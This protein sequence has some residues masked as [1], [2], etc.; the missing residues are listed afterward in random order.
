MRVE[1]TVSRQHGSVSTPIVPCTVAAVLIFG[2]G[3]LVLGSTALA[4]S[5]TVLTFGIVLVVSAL[6][7]MV[8]LTRH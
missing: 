7:R 6:V 5:V 2:T 3:V 1:T 4:A 8:A